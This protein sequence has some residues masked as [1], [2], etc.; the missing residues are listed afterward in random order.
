MRFLIQIFLVFFIF[1]SPMYA[2]IF[3]SE[4]A[5][6][7]SYNKYLEIYNYSDEIVNLYPDFVLAS[8]TNG[9]LDGNN[10]YINEFQEGS[11]IAPGEVYVIAATQADPVILNQAD[12]TFQYCC[13]NGDDAYAIMLSGSVGEFFDSDN[14]IDIIGN[15][16]TWQE[17]VGWDVA[18]V[19]EATENHT[20]VRKSFV[21]SGNQG[22]WSMS[23]GTNAENSEW[24]VL[25]IDDWSNIG[26]HDYDNSSNSILGCMCEAAS[27]YMA[28]ATIDDGSCVVDGGCSDPLA[29]NYSGDLCLSAEFTNEDCDYTITN[30]SGCLDESACNY[31]DFDYQITAS[32]MTIA[33]VDISNLIYGDMVGVFYL[34]EN[35]FISCGGSVVFED[36]QMALAAWSDDAGTLSIDGFEAADQFIFLLLRDNVVYETMVTLNNLAPFNNTYLANGFGQ[37]TSLSIGDEFLQDCITPPLGYDCDGNSIDLSDHVLERYLVRTLDILGRTIMDKTDKNLQIMI[38]NDGSVEKKHVLSH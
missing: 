30:M 31:F 12:S 22:N 17:G 36:D 24:L 4:Y 27:N 38:F 28:T 10:F 21:F 25:E 26:F 14:A 33:I 1:S 34:D 18:G 6:G 35:E 7:S 9:C 13:G 11:S 37:I 23:S 29:L 16:D 15:E 19:A 5:E 8:C 2:Q 32:N 3:F 20:L